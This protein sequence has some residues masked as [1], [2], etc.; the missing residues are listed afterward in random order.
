M[1]R[2]CAIVGLLC[3]WVLWMEADVIVAGKSSRFWRLLGAEEAK[4]GCETLR[5]DKIKAR[6][7]PPTGDG[8]KLKISGSMVD[9]TNADKGIYRTY[10]YWCLP[11]GTD[12]RPRS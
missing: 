12:P 6:H 3:G 9:E 10:T 5:T 11:A 7:T 2:S 4:A 1:N 8:W